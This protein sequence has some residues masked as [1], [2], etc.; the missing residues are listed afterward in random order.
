MRNLS[1][2]FNAMADM[3]VHRAQILELLRRAL[4][5][6][7]SN[8]V[9]EKLHPSQV[10]MKNAIEQIRKKMLASVLIPH[11]RRTLPMRAAS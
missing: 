6:S 3:V 7:I 10:T 4:V 8:E 9:L 5:L 2:Y 11:R 1:A